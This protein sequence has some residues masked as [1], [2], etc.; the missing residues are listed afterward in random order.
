MPPKVK[1]TK[2]DAVHAAMEIVKEKG[3]QELTMRKVADRL[4]S[5]I[6]PVYSC[7]ETKCELEQTVIE[8]TKKILS[9]HASK[10]YTD[11]QPLNMAIGL[12]LFARDYP[13][14]FRS[15]FFQDQEFKAIFETFNQHHIEH[16]ENVDS[17]NQL[18]AKERQKLLQRLWMF[19]FGFATLMC[20]GPVDDNSDDNVISTLLE[21]G[22]RIINGEIE[23]S[24]G[25]SD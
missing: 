1:F 23:S 14:L 3:F 20:I 2:T 8:E 5:S 6:Q 24:A 21:V 9:T 18:C 10:M 7:F 22:Q 4:G 25:Y 11:S 15:I 17:F 12:V 13:Q 19:T 16:M